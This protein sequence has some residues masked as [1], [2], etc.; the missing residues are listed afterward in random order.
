M[1]NQLGFRRMPRAVQHEARAM[2]CHP[3]EISIVFVEQQD[4]LFFP[5]RAAI[6]FFA[7]FFCMFA[8][9]IAGC[10]TMP[11]PLLAI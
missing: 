1:Q 7:I 10:R 3:M 5:R 11:R 6:L 8:D 2:V 4:H 9:L